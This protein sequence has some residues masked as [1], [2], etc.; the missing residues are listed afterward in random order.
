MERPILI[1][2]ASKL[3]GM[4]NLPD[5]ATAGV[6]MIHG[7][8]GYRTGPHRILVNTSAALARRGIASLRF[9]LRGRGASLEPDC[10][11]DLD[12]MIDDALAAVRW[13]REHPGIESVFLLGICSGG[14]VTLG[15]ASLDKSLDGIILWSTPLF[16]PFKTKGQAAQRRNLVL[17]EY[18]RKLLRPETYL[19]LIKGKLNLGLIRRII[20]GKEQQPAGSGRN[21]KDSRR[22]IMSDLDGFAGPALFIYGS[23]DDEAIGAPEFYREWCGEHG[24]PAA[25]HTVQGANHSYYSV[26]WE[27]EVIEQTIDWME[28]PNGR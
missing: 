23:L 7:W 22:D 24:V 25:F 13:M 1:E 20:F 2:S 16:A 5:G 17:A 19:K 3:P 8:G 18:A 12:G 10:E 27:R 28:S 15:A 9:D 4:L 21:P 11:T 26:A 6:V 14:N